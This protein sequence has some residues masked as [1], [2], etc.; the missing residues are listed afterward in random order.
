MK[1][2][3]ISIILS[4]LNKKYPEAKTALVHSNPLQLLVSTIL[5][6][7]CTD[8]L[9]NSAVPHLFEKYKSAKDYANAKLE[10]LESDINKINFYK[11]KARAII[12]C[13]KKLVEEYRGMV[14]D[15]IDSLTTLPGVGR[16]TA[17]VV[18]GQAFGIP[19]VVVDTHV[20]RVAFR[21]GLTKNKDPEKIERDLMDSIPKNEWTFFT[22]A[23][24]WHGRQICK[25]RNPLCSECF[26]NKVC[27]SAFKF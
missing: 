4:M 11:N 7:Q 5:S 18:L 26:L 22:S 2:G 21:L 12:G 17:N 19:S 1:N 25:A 3:N 16:K 23:L 24:I 20:K 10:E 6:A 8:K 27:P 13:C 14:P 15:S 9:V